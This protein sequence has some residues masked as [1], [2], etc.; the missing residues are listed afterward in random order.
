VTFEVIVNAVERFG[1]QVEQSMLGLVILISSLLINVGLTLWQGHW[2][3]RID[4]EIL[5]ANVT[6][7]LSDVLTSA[8]VFLGWQLAANIG[9]IRYLR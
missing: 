3:K 9:L 8:V 5:H 6:H 1:P 2:T 7:T 4:S